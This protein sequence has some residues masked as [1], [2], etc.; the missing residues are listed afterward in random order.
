MFPVAATSVV[1]DPRGPATAGVAD[2]QTLY[3]GSLAGVFV[4]RNITPDP[5]GPAPVWR[6]LNTALPLTLIR[7]IEYGRYRDP[8]GTL[9]RRFLR[10]ATSG[11]STSFL[12][13]DTSTLG[14]ALRHR[15]RPMCAC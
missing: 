4:S 10:A 1:I 8:R 5:G 13:L 14:A 2:L 9:V 7:D 15:R 3:F 6:T 11:R 12:E